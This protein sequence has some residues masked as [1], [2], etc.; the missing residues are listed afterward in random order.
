MHEGRA[1]F[2]SH[3]RELPACDLWGYLSEKGIPA[4]VGASRCGRREPEPNAGCLYE[5][6]YKLVKMSLT[7]ELKALNYIFCKRYSKIQ[8]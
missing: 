5:Y 6:C 8:Q 4:I 1:H 2:E 3:F 7:L